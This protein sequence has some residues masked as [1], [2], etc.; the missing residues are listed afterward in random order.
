EQTERQLE[1][2]TT[3]LNRQ[4]R[5]LRALTGQ[6]AGGSRKV[7][8]FAAT[9]VAAL[10]P[11]DRCTDL[12]ALEQRAAGRPPA[13]DDAATLDELAEL[14]ALRDTGQYTAASLRSGPLV[15]RVQAQNNPSL[16]AEALLLHGDVLVRTDRGEEAGE[17]LLKALWAAEDGGHD[18]ARAMAWL[19][20]LYL[21]GYQQAN[22][23]QGER[24]AQHAQAVLARIGGDTTLEARRLSV[25]GLMYN[26]ASQLDTAL[27][28]QREAVALLRRAQ[29]LQRPRLAHALHGLANT[30]KDL[31]NDDAAEQSYREALA[32]GVEV[33][34]ARHPDVGKTQMGLGN[35]LRQL[36]RRDEAL[37]MY[38]AGLET[39]RVVHGERSR[40]VAIARYNLATIY[41]DRGAYKLALH[42]HEAVAEVF[43]E[44]LPEG[45]PH[46]IT[47]AN[48]I[49]R[50]QHLLGDLDAAEATLRGVVASLEK[51][52]AEGTQA[53]A[54]IAL[55]S[56]L[57]FL[58]Q[59][60]IARPEGL[61]E[62]LQVYVRAEAI[63]RDRLG[64]EHPM[65]V[66]V[67]LNRGDALRQAG[68][69]GEAQ[70]VLE[71]AI[72]LGER[73]DSPYT[74]EAMT[75]LGALHREQGELGQAV[76]ALRRGLSLAA[77]TEIEPIKLA[78]LRFELA[79]C[80]WP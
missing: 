49:G 18:R 78:L 66:A 46:R 3:C 5:N 12:E 79:R 24:L 35:V 31:G 23:A 55:G 74:A 22:V 53:V 56:A 30:Q 58:G 8:E 61:R 51:K 80:L 29:G 73:T 52:L 20:L 40:D 45:H 77:K 34:G 6:L 39:L 37:E 63:Y 43:A 36:G 70:K 69:R 64:P 1:L 57:N 21:H 44:L 72:A 67:M 4:L 9:A 10:E 65:I 50:E 11:L 48:A 28:H 54:P 19:D 26:D 2:R 13:G 76:T 47:V 17:V 42:E 16:L 14:Q 75:S 27:T 71:Q 33:H 59:V 38:K 68:K 25:L 7:G 60:L 62:A 15:E 41:S 32:I